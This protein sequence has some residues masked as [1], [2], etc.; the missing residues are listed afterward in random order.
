MEIKKILL[1]GEFSGFHNSL[2]RGL[3]HLGHNA[4]LA[5]SRDGFKDL[6]VDINLFPHKKFAKNKFLYALLK[7]FTMLARTKNLKGF[8]IVQFISPMRFHNSLPVYGGKYNAYIYNKL[9]KNNAK[10]F[11]VACGNDPVYKNIGRNC[12]EYNPIDAQME[13]SAKKRYKPNKKSFNWNVSLAKKVRGVIPATYEYRIG[14]EQV[15]EGIT[16]SDTIPIPIMTS[17]YKY[18]SNTLHKGKIRILHGIS[19]PG[20]KGS[21]YILQALDE[22][23][24]YYPNEVEV[25]VVKRLSLSEYLSKVQSCNVLIDQCN[26]YA[27]GIN[28]LIGLALG[29]VVLSGA[30]FE[31]LKALKVNQSPVINIRP[32]I[33]Q[34]YQQVKKVILNKHNI[35]SHGKWSREYVE[36]HHD[37]VKVAKQYL[38]FWQRA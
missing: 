6:A 30:E 32:D 14:Y 31:E 19:R 12:L 38:A 2:K 10:S 4:T 13:F 21:N 26:S 11:L 1:I 3:E 16:L 9:I 28:A 23:K 22:I 34:I 36:K 15:G 7:Q 25:E 27:Y 18:T 24:H 20:M 33:T 37:A 8:D 35:E 29:K 17:D 5:G